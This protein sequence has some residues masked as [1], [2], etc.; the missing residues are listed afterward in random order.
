[1]I[2]TPSDY[3]MSRWFLNALKP[4]ILGTVV[5]YG[6]NSENSDLD[7]IFEMAKLVDSMRSAN[8]PNRVVLRVL[9]KPQTSRQRLSQVSK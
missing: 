5:H 4:E 7:T 9:E 3:D 8:T 1:M 6:V 2:Q